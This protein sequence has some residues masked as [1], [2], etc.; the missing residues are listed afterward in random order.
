MKYMSSLLFYTYLEI[1]SK[2]LIIFK[3]QEKWKRVMIFFLYII[4]NLFEI[5]IN[6]T[7]W[8]L[9]NAT[10]IIINW[11]VE[12]KKLIVVVLPD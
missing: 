9:I 6:N 1:E 7:T 4:N 12:E 2:K 11:P 8:K 5:N 3:I 10:W